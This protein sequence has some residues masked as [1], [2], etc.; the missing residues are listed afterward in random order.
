MWECLP[1]PEGF[2]CFDLTG[3]TL[4]EPKIC[5][6]GSYCPA[7]TGVDGGNLCPM[8]EFQPEMGRHACVKCP[9]GKYC[10]STG[11]VGDVVTGA[12]VGIKDCD[13]GFYCKEGNTS[14]T[15]TFGTGGACAVGE[16]CDAGSGFPRP[17][18]PGYACTSAQM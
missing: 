3:G 13:A 1:C 6:P 10:G 15:P 5:P 11:L 17:A 9:A 16:Y 7:N 12:A 8:G 4:V 14:G 2:Y 18:E